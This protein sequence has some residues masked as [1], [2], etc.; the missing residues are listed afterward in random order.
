MGLALNVIGPVRFITEQN[1]ARVIHPELVPP[2]GSSGLDISYVAGLG[3]DA[4]PDLLRVL[5]SLNTADAIYLRA[6]LAFR[7]DQLDADSGLNAW[8]AWNAGRAG[9]RDALDAARNAGDLP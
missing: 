3:D 1:V 4:V 2:T 9:A 7:L 8:Q 5:P 6:E